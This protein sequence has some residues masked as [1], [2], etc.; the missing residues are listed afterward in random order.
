[1]KTVQRQLK[2][3]IKQTIWKTK[4][5]IKNIAKIKYKR[6]DVFPEEISKIALSSNDDKRIQSIDLTEPYAYGMS[7]YLVFKKKEIKCNNTIKQYKNF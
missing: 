5:K 4:I 7:Q 2:L 1:M 6:H 3:K